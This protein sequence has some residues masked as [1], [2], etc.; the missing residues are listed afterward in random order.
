MNLGEKVSLFGKDSV[1]NLNL[2]STRKGIVKCRTMRQCT[3]LYDIEVL[4]EATGTPWNYV[5]DTLVGRKA[6]KSDEKTSAK[7]RN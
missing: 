6:D 4:A 5:Q 7:Q 2:V 1:S 3:P